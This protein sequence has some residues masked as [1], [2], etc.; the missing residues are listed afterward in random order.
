[1]KPHLPIALALIWR[2]GKILLSRRRPDADHLPDVWEFPGGKVEANETPAL[3]AV[4]EA[5]EE[6]GLVVE[7]VAERALIEWEYE[8]RIVTL[9]PFDCR[10]VSGII[11]AREVAEWKWLSPDELDSNDFPPANAELIKSL[12]QEKC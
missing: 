5:Q 6:I 10:V 1:M 3:A 8:K 12:Q 11:Q 4:R 7:V 9:H 2:E